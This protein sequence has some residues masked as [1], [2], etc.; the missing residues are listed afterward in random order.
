MDGRM[1][2]AGCVVATEPFWERRAAAR[3]LPELTH[4]TSHLHCMDVCKL[5]SV[6]HHHAT[7]CLGSG[8]SAR[9]ANTFLGK[10]SHRL[11]PTGFPRLQGLKTV[12]GFGADWPDL[13]LT[14]GLGAT[15]RWRKGRAAA[16]LRFEY[17]SQEGELPPGA[18]LSS[19]EGEDCLPTLG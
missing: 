3:L 13:D 4:S 6:F 7:L 19:K 10:Q 9:F 2:L 5:K 8:S 16:L 1:D 12:G 11:R 14:R 15:W 17:A 18:V